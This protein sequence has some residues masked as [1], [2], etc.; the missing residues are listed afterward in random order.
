[1]NT[2]VTETPECRPTR[3]DMWVLLVVEMRRNNLPAPKAV[4]INDDGVNVE[5]SGASK[6]AAWAKHLDAETSS[7]RSAIGAET[8]HVVQ[9]HTWHGRY[10]RVYGYEPLVAPMSDVTATLV[11]ELAASVTS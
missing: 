4:E 11:D 7:R 3:D 2:K 9:L 8:I 10:L 5:L 1:M 6:V